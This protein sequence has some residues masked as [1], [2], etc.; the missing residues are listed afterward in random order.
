[1]HPL[2]ALEKL[3]D[4]G[5]P[6]EEV[7]MDLQLPWDQMRST[8]RSTLGEIFAGF[9]TYYAKFDFDRWAIS[10]RLGQ[11][12]SLVEKIK[13]LSGGYQIQFACSYTIFVEGE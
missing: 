12:F 9:I 7:D 4:S 11:P 6:V 8:N 2:H 3:F 13:Q 1:M 5:R 10:I